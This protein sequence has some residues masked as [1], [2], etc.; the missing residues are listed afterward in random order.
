MTSTKPKALLCAIAPDLIE[1]LQM[2]LSV[3]DTKILSNQTDFENFLESPQDSQFQIFICGDAEGAA[4]AN[5]FGQVLRQQSATGPILFVTK[6]R[7]D[8]NRATFIKNG[9]TDALLW[10]SDKPLLK[11][12]AEEI[13][14]QS[15]ATKAS[16]RPIFASDVSIDAALPF[17]TFVFLPLNRK[18]VPFSTKGAPL[19]PEKKEKLKVKEVGKIYVDQ[20]DVQS[21]YKFTADNLKRNLN[22]M[23]ETERNEKLQASVRRMFGH[24]FDQSVSG[25]FESGRDALVDCQKIISSYVTNGRSTDWYGQLVRSLGGALNSYDHAAVVSSVGAM[26]AI[27]IGH[28]KPEDIA[29]AGFFHDVGRVD[30]DDDLMLKPESEWPQDLRASYPK[31]PQLSVNLLKDKKII[32]PNEVEKAILQHHERF[33]GKGF[34]KQLAGERIIEEAQIVSFADQFSYLSIEQEGK[35]RIS[36]KDAFTAIRDNGSISPALLKK[37]ERLFYGDQKSE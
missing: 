29:L 16:Y 25:T 15:G 34:P 1:P 13:L 19:T 27:G 20:K 22:Q 26:I 23:S 35:A 32:L 14:A 7:E 33:D 21:F 6:K 24:L 37:I 8:F 4:F 18:Y 10:P 11:Q 2:T 30:I 9:Y 28:P 17:G 31:H 12:T 5:E 3:W 36:P